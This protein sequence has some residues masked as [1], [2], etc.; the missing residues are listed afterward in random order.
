[1]TFNGDPDL[2]KKVI[3][4]DEKWVYGFDIETKTQSSQWKCPEEP[5]TKKARQVQSNVK[6]LLT[7]FIDCNG[8]IL[9]WS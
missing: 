9:P 3:T 1:M 2:L 5:R 4:D 8:G 6:V 7:V